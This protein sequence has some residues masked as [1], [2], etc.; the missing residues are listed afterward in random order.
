L[1]RDPCNYSRRKIWCM[2]VEPWD[3]HS[4]CTN[5]FIEQ[6]VVVEQVA[7]ISVV[8]FLYLSLIHDSGIV[9]FLFFFTPVVINF[10]CMKPC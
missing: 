7:L 6:L 8:E 3:V 4:G 5:N 9:W 1:L 2:V 10:C